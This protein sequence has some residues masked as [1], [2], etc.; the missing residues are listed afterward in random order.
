M[1]LLNYQKGNYVILAALAVVF[2]LRENSLHAA[3]YYWDGNGATAGV[4]GSGTWSGA[5]FSPSSSGGGTLVRATT[6][7]TVNFDAA[8]GGAT[9]TI[10]TLPT[11]TWSSTNL[12]TVN[13]N[14]SYS[15]TNSGSTATTLNVN[16]VNIAAGTTLT[17]NTTMQTDFAANSGTATFSG[18]GATSILDLGMLT[19]SSTDFKR[20]TLNNINLTNLSVRLSGAGSGGYKGFVVATGTTT[21]GA[22]ITNNTTDAL[23]LGANSSR[24]LNLYGIVSGSGR[25]AFSSGQSG[26]AGTI[27]L[28]SSN[29]Y[30]GV[31]ELNNSTTGTLRLQTNNAIS[32]VSTLQHGTISGNGGTLDLNAFNQTLAGLQSGVGTGRITNSAVGLSILTIN[33]TTDS[34]YGLSIGGNIALVKTNTGNLALTV[35]NAYSG[36]TTVSGGTLTASNTSALGTGSVTVG[37]GATLSVRANVSNTVANSGTVSIGAGGTLTAASLGT[38]ALSLAGVLGT[39]ASFVSTQSDSTL[40]I[41]ALTLGGY[42]SFSMASDKSVTSSGAITLSGTNNSIALTGSG[43]GVGTYSLFTGSSISNGSLASGGLTLGG[44]GVGNSTVVLNGSQAIVGRTTYDFTSTSTALQ[45]VVSGGAWNMGWNA[46]NGAWD[47]TAANWQRDGVGSNVAFYA[48]DNATLGTANTL[49]IDGAGVTAGTVAANASTGTTTLAG[50]NLIAS[51]LSKSGAGALVISNAVTAINGMTQSAGTLTTAGSLSISNNGVNLNGGTASLNGNN[52]IV[53]GGLNVAGA[54]VTLNGSNTISGGGLNISSGSLTVNSTNMI[55][56]GLNVTGGTATINSSSNSITGGVNANGGVLVVNADGALGNNTIAMNGGSLGLG[57]L[58]TVTNAVSLG[59]SGGAVTNDANFTLSGSVTGSGNTLTKNGSGNL[60]LSGG[61]GASGAGIGLNLQQG[62]VILSGSSGKFLTNSIL[63]GNL[64]VSNSALITRGSTFGGTG[65]VQIAGTSLWSNSTSQSY[66]SNAAVL[67]TGANL[68]SSNASSS[69]LHLM[70]GLGGT[71]NVTAIGAGGLY[72]Y[73]NGFNGELTNN[74]TGEIRLLNA[75]VSGI[76]AYRGTGSTLT[77]SNST[78]NRTVGGLISGSQVLNIRGTMVTTFTNTQNDFTNTININGSQSG[79]TGRFVGNSMG[80]ATTTAE[81]SLGNANT[82][83]LDGVTSQRNLGIKTGGGTVWVD[84]NSSL[85]NLTNNT[86]GGMSLTKDGAGTLTFT[87]LVRDDAS[88]NAPVLNIKAGRVTLAASSST[89]QYISVAGTTT[90]YAGD[91]EISAGNQLG[92]QGS[93]TMGGGGKLIFSGDDAA[94]QTSSTTANNGAALTVANDV[95][96][97]GAIGTK[98]NIAATTSNTMALN[99]VKGTGDLYFGIQSAGGGSGQIQLKDILTFTG[100]VYMN[101]TSNGVVRLDTVNVLGNNQ[102]LIMN[103]NVGSGIVDFN[104]N[105]Q[106]LVSLES[107]NNDATYTG[108]LTSS[109]AATLSLNQSSDTTYGGTI[110]GALALVKNGTGI[111]TLAASNA[112]TGGVTI[113][114]GGIYLTNSSK[115]LGSGTLTLNGGRLGA[116]SSGYIVTNAVIISADSTFGK[117][118]GNGNALTLSGGVNLNGGTRVVGL[119]NSVTFS[120]AITNGGLVIDS[121]LNRNFTI[122]GDSTYAGG[123][124]VRGGNFKLSGAG[125]LNSTGAFNLAAT[126]TNATLDISGLTNAGATIGSLAGAMNS[127]VNLGSRNLDLGGNNASTSYAGVIAGASGSLTKSG[128]GKFTLAGSNS[129]SGATTVNAGTLEV[130]AGANIG[131]S[132]S[133]VNTNAILTVNGTAGDV[134]VNS[135]GTLNGSGAVSALS[136]ASGGTLAVGNSPGTLTASSAIWNGGGTYEWE[137]N[138]FLG[139]SGSNWDFLNVTGALMISANSGNK[140]IVDVISLLA[141]NNTAGEASNFD[142]FSNYS[143]AIATAAGGISGFD[144]AAFQINTAGFANSMLPPGATGPGSWSITQSGN[145]INLNYASAI[146]EPTTGSL[147]LI[148]LL[149]ALAGRRFRRS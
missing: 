119:D 20:I 114:Q 148:G 6:N 23:V 139:S 1:V 15:L 126:T 41:G 37:S 133:T 137:I 115:A 131:S 17:L 89:A 129:Y 34:S 132:A 16:S 31:T 36:G 74:S 86:S 92:I 77:F 127:S 94:L 81:V 84:R 99:K 25:V 42:S 87:G 96:L 59:A 78:Q 130:A 39:N 58:S 71:G 54:A 26:G 45:L 93:G 124:T 66:V 141:S 143:F 53:S 2:A 65:Q 55:S 73:G 33:Q 7:D 38:G 5:N 10:I 72:I 43:L 51:S 118:D 44:T 21:I 85:G 105:N 103:R 101:L 46:G 113:N 75:D 90:N 134:T 56:G 12:G 112:L 70:G 52:T 19:T 135:G 125:A 142:A 106:S 138:N 109:S 145:S 104:G 147:L 3:T 128:T 24:T 79:T 47:Y 88:S 121:T 97:N 149:G 40:S 102:R 68:V 30:T 67:V 95:V 49:T 35:S 120:G 117:T 29:S 4:G 122:S 22:N 64:V 60:N 111:I 9:G 14:S 27:N 32:T 91:L 76:T 69:H 13:F 98:A 100:N 136:I 8:A 63:N 28:Y 61:V 57:T 107:L 50:G 83:S 62:T 82:L 144:V 80:S 48:N 110:D 18:A 146:P 11:A 123:T 116:L 108:V 140:F